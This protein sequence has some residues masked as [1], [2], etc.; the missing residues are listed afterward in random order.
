MQL[1]ITVYL[2]ARVPLGV[3]FSVK[4]LGA[5]SILDG[6]VWVNMWEIAYALPVWSRTHGAVR[7]C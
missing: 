6:N 4:R 2:G 7:V 1:V 5:V 3:P